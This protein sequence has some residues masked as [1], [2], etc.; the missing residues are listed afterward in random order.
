LEAHIVK[1]A[2]TD[3]IQ[4]CLINQDEQFTSTSLYQ[5]CPFSGIALKI[6]NLWLVF[7]NRI[8]TTDN[9]QKKYWKGSKFCKMYNAEET[10]DHLLFCC[11]VAVFMWSVIRDG[12]KWTNTPEECKE[13]QR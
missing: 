12:L 6:K 9:L 13:L 7:K 10:V 11:L 4:R 8:Q 5:H 2:D 1:H 3:T